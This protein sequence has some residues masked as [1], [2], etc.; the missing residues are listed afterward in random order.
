MLRPGPHRRLDALR[1]AA[2]IAVRLVLG[3][4]PLLVVAGLIEGFVSPAPRVPHAFKL[5]FGP[6]TAFVL[7]SWLL[8][9]PP[10]RFGR[11]GSESVPA[12]GVSG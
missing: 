3:S 9:A 5:L 2:G 10:P 1:R 7:Y 4:A 8:L 12:P 6:A 11:R